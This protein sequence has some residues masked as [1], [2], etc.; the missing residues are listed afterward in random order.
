[1]TTAEKATNSV[2]SWTP[3]SPEMSKVYYLM[4]DTIRYSKATDPRLQKK[5]CNCSDCTTIKGQH[6]PAEAGEA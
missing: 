1:M 3:G 2:K 5:Q 6:V 4:D